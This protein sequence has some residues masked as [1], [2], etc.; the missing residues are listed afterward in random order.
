MMS[1]SV[2]KRGEAIPSEKGKK[3]VKADSV[4][5]SQKLRPIDKKKKKEKGKEKE[6]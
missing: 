5:G 2:T 3:S 1:K 4:S 6:R